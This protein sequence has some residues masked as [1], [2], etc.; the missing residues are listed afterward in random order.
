MRKDSKNFTLIELLVVIAI[1]AILAAMLLPALNKARERARA[2]SCVSNLKQLGTL[3]AMYGDEYGGLIHTNGSNTAVANPGYVNILYKA[4]YL[5]RGER[6]VS[7]PSVEPPTEEQL[8]FADMNQSYHYGIIG[9]KNGYT[10]EYIQYFFR[11]NGSDYIATAKMK[12]PSR[13][14]LIS[15]TE[16]ST[17][18][19]QYRS[20]WLAYGSNAGLVRMRHS[21]M[22]NILTAGGNVAQADSGILMNDYAPYTLGFVNGRRIYWREYEQVTSQSTNVIKAIL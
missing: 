11:S 14:L 16:H 15:D 21:R 1:I 19:R 22:A 13:F 5:K 2:A 12:N 18:Y 20:F 9:D 8:N 7:C 10:N 6:F 4:G 3:V 17:S